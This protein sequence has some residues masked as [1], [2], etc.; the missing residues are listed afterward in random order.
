M[1]FLWFVGY[2][3][4]TYGNYELAYWVGGGSIIL[5]GLALIPI[6]YTPSNSLEQ[7]PAPY[8]I[9][10]RI[11]ASIPV[12]SNASSKVD[13]HLPHSVYDLRYGSAAGSFLS[14]ISNS[15]SAS[16]GNVYLSMPKL[17]S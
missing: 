9:G 14:R 3:Y 12:L 10:E 16:E 13:V 2:L 1:Y 17:V 6:L 5:A 7:L 15:K 4:T 11:I 8:N